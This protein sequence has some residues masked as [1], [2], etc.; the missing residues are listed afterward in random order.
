MEE[1]GAEYAWSDA[2]VQGDEL[3]W[4]PDL[5][6][7]KVNELSNR[8]AYLKQQATFRQPGS[9]V[10][11]VPLDTPEAQNSEMAMAVEL[12]EILDPVM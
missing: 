2:S 7:E 11:G 9:T 12:G 3:A 4:H 8:R 1:K 6:Q 5:A 10:R